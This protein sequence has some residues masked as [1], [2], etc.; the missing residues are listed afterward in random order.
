M[1]VAWRAAP[2]DP[3][4]TDEPPVGEFWSPVSLPGR[5][6][7]FAGETHLAYRTT[8]DDPRSDPA[9]PVIMSLH[10]C[11]GPFAVWLN[12]DL[13][14]R[15]RF[16]IRRHHLPMEVSEGTNEVILLCGWPTHRFT[17]VLG[18]DEL[19][20]ELRV[21]SPW[22]ELSLRVV[23]EPAVIDVTGDPRCEGEHGRVS[24]RALVATPRAMDDAVE[25]T[26]RPEGLSTP[27]G[28]QAVEVSLDRGSIQTVEGELSV[29]S[30]HRW[31]PRPDGHRGLY[32][33]EGAVADHEIDSR[34]AFRS[35]SFAEGAVLVNSREVP[36]RGFTVYPGQPP[37]R[38]LERAVEANATAIRMR[39]HV[40]SPAMYDACLSTG[41]LVWQ[42]VPLTGPGPVPL[43]DGVEVARALTQYLRGKGALG[44][45]A[46]HDDPTGSLSRGHSSGALGRLRRSWRHF[47]RSY[48]PATI[49]RM[50]DTLRDVAPTIPTV[51][52]PG[53]ETSARALFPGVVHGEVESTRALLE[54]YPS[55]ILAA[56][57]APAMA[58]PRG[59]VSPRLRSTLAGHGITSSH[60]SRTHQIA[61]CK[62]AIE[63]ARMLDYAGTIVETLF[64]RRADGGYGVVTRDNERKPAFQAVADSFEPVQSVLDPPYSTGRPTVVLLNDTSTR[65]D[66]TITVEA[67]PER[68]EFRGNAPP[69]SA[70]EIAH[71]DL[72]TDLTE[73]GLTTDSENHSIT[74]SYDLGHV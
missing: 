14:H 3:P 23:T 42:D 16:P 15:I 54:R 49:E 18:D 73:I 30:I 60:A 10:G 22:W 8:F 5:P 65:I 57:G 28:R 36:L 7:S 43:D 51:A 46:V 66:A 12:G 2:V 52:G 34:I 56:T 32:R 33:L 29:P 13:Q 35:L 11:P 71:V 63:T 53:V 38:V 20:D 47:R 55:S 69:Y 41:L 4:T 72:P 31:H 6:V 68:H 59:A 17:G 37:G 27:G 25:F 1:D 74:N 9:D 40:A 58:S 39:G 61:V 45:I 19:D 44:V 26:V 50:A 48:D 24:C 70:R 67:G 62:T 64:D 21:P